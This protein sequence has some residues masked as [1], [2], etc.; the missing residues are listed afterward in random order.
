MA[1]ASDGTRGRLRPGVERFGIE[2][3]PAELRTVGW[4]DLFA[5]L[6]TFNLSPLVYVLGALAVTVGGLPLWWAAGA[7]GAGALVGTTVLSLAGR[8]GVDDGLPGQVAM[9]A[10]FG[11]WGARGLTSMFRFITAA[12]WFGAQALGA[13]F[14][15]TVLID[16]L[17]G[18]RFGLGPVAV[19]F[20]AVSVLLAALGFDALRYFVRFVGPLI[21]SFVAILVV[22]YLTTDE[23]AFGL[24]RVLSPTDLS[25]TWVG[26]AAFF[27]VAAGGQL[28]FATNIADFCRYARSRVHMR[29]GIVG[30]STV[31]FFS[32]SW[33]GAYS[34]TA[35]GS[36]NPY[37]ATAGITESYPILIFLLVALSAQIISVNVLNLYTGG[38]SLV[39]T[40]PRLGRLASTL[41]AGAVS[42]AVSGFP[43]FIEEADEW[44]T[45]I[46]SLGAALAGVILADYT[47]LARSKIDVPALFDPKGRYRF[48]AGVNPA[49][50]G[51]VAIGTAA[52]Y[53]AP[54]GW[55]KVAWGLV[56]G[57]VSY[58]A[59]AVPQAVA[60]PQIG[61]RIR[62]LRHAMAAHWDRP[63]PQGPEW[64]ASAL[65]AEIGQSLHE[66]RLQQELSLA[67]V[68]ESLGISATYVSALEEGTFD[69]IP[70]Q[71][72]A[73]GFLQAYAKHLNLDAQELLHE[74][75]SLSTHRP[76]PPSG[77][78]AAAL[79]L[80]G[81]VILLAGAGV[82]I[83][84]LVQERASG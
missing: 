57:F 31:G 60:F 53:A 82:A 50:M 25:F 27:T 11:E 84:Q 18:H 68:Q 26:V 79:A 72:H 69:R 41:V 66:S 64:A 22:L 4:H 51:A 54:D 12:Y 40:V 36:T 67:A 71:S 21:I 47:L 48:L 30:G 81:S 76:A 44:F 35:T 46:G 24:S 80:A 39:N 19:V 75:D 7:M 45:H 14:G 78:T 2:P 28:S 32:A 58:L 1:D 23:P 15:I 70:S 8:A 42:L 83:W 33:L 5:I 9:R 10:T 34:A 74:F 63:A 37:V 38:L 6:C 43:A 61:P 55:I 49:A 77:R 52:F 62:A 17:T 3:I 29:I 59:L 56:V 13:A 73:R 20:G 16:A 65:A